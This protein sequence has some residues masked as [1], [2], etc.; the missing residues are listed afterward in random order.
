MEAFAC[1]NNK[2]KFKNLR[3]F[4][5][6][7]LRLIGLSGKS[8]QQESQLMLHSLDGVLP[9]RINDKLKD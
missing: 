1:I 9:V 8:P 5:E 3:F 7:T 4:I 6:E 2:G